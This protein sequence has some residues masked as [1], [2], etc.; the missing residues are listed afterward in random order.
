[1]DAQELFAGHI[2]NP[3]RI[4]EGDLRGGWL[5]LYA[6][7]I[8][9]AARNN[10]YE[11]QKEPLDFFTGYAIAFSCSLIFWCV[12]GYLI[13]LIFRMVTNG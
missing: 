1:M 9:A 6:N 5:E 8:E 3:P 2:K 13:H 11:L 7:S 12:V 10:Q 4:P